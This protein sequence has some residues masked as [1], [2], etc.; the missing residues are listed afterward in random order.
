MEFIALFYL[1]YSKAHINDANSLK[2]VAK[3]NNNKAKKLCD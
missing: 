1:K 3:Q 2:Q